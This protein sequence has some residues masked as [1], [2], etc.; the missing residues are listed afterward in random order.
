MGGQ[1]RRMAGRF[2]ACFQTS[3]PEPKVPPRRSFYVTPLIPFTVL[4][5]FDW[6]FLL[7]VSN[8]EIPDWYLGP[9][10]IRWVL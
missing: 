7:F 10:E 8:H 4:A 2:A 3:Q 1:P 5:S 6:I 9:E